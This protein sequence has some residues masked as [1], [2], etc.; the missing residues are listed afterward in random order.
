M[1]SSTDI[2]VFLRKMMDS[3]QELEQ[4]SKLPDD[5]QRET[6]ELRARLDTEIHKLDDC[7]R[8][9]HIYRCQLEEV[10]SSLDTVRG[11]MKELEEKKEVE[12]QTLKSEHQSRMDE[13]TGKFLAEKSEL[14]QALE[15]EHELELDNF[16]EK[17]NKIEN[18]QLQALSSD[19]ESLKLKLASKEKEV[20]ELQRN[21]ND[22]NSDS[23]GADYS[24]QLCQEVSKVEERLKTSHKK[25]LEELKQRKNEEM[26]QRMEEVRQKMLDSS[27]LSVERMKTKL[28]RQQLQKLAEKEEE[29]QI[30]FE[31]KIS[32]F[33]N[34]KQWELEEVREKVRKKSKLE[35]ESLRSRF[36]MMQA[37][38]T[39]ERSPSVSESEFTM[40]VS[41][42]DIC[43]RITIPLC[44]L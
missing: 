43:P 29:L 1:V 23:G 35:I 5:H 12:L 18:Q 20:E 15:L 16:K 32:E 17:T 40:E 44:R 14:R 9:I 42:L 27:Q 2:R 8:E 7:H 6:E 10:N 34:A 4:V 41:P 39:M 28:E 3:L 36:K 30:N 19:I 25:E 24:D 13:I 11:E 33:E 38:G 22:Q 26:L 37:T 31:K 21:L